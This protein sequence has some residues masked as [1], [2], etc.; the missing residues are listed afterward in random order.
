MKL[1]GNVNLTKSG[2]GMSISA[3]HLDMEMMGIGSANIIGSDKIG[4]QRKEPVVSSFAQYIGVHALSQAVDDKVGRI[5]V[6][7]SPLDLS[8]SEKGYFQVQ[9][10]DKS[11]ELTRDGRFKLNA[12]NELINTQGN[13][14]LSASGEPIVLPF[15]PNEIKDIKINKKGVVSVFNNDTRK[16]VNAGQIGVVSAEGALVTQGCVEQGTL[17]YS[18]V[19]IHQEFMELTTV[20]RNFDA[21]RQLFM[22]QNS[23]LSRAIQEL[24]SG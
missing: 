15:A 11:I 16:M 9:H 5:M 23:K 13:K 12:Q 7:G 17:E 1:Q 2:L 22:L 24:G 3:M 20:K 8:L 10:K 4:Y 19:A 18:N 14:V 21:N 6:S